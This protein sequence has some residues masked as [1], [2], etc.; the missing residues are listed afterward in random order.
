MAF[1][2]A[3]RRYGILFPSEGIRL[4]FDNYFLFGTLTVNTAEWQITN[5]LTDR[6]LFAPCQIRFA[7]AAARKLQ[8]LLQA[9]YSAE[10]FIV[11]TH[12]YV[13]AEDQ[14][15]LVFGS[16]TELHDLSAFI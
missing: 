10:P 4:A 5:L 8:R 13:F 1:P 14:P 12:E 2:N 16:T 9:D 15:K 11:N 3:T 6:A 7:P